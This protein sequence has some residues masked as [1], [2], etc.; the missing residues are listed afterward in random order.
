MLIRGDRRGRSVDREFFNK[1]DRDRV[2]WAREIEHPNQTLVF[3]KTAGRHNLVE[4]VV[5]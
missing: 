1:N 4:V 3:T 5:I 2:S